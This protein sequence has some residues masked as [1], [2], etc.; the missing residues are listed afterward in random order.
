MTLTKE[1]FM[2][3][4]KEIETVLKPLAAKYGCIVEAGGIR[5]DDILTT[6]SVN[7]KTETIDKTAD[8]LNFEQYCGR[9]GFTAEDFGLTFSYEGKNYTLTHFRTSARKYPCMCIASDGK[10]YGFA[11]D[12]V[13]LLTKMKKGE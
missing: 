2:A 7:F 1:Q 10:T 13:K 8:Q 11:P 5:Y 9:Y 4:R 6:V 3:F 12:A